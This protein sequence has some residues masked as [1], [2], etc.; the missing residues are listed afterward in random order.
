VSSLCDL[1]LTIKLFR[2]STKGLSFSQP[3]GFVSPIEAVGT[4]VN[5]W[6]LKCTLGNIS[7]G[8]TCLSKSLENLSLEKSMLE[9]GKNGNESPSR[10]KLMKCCGAE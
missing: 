2:Q 10:P 1:S 5:I 9:A 6:F 4:P 8:G 7:M 3:V